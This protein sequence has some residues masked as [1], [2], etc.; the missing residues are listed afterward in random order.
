MCEKRLLYHQKIKLSTFTT[1]YWRLRQWK[2]HFMKDKV[3][4]HYGE[5]HKD[6]EVLTDDQQKIEIMTWYV[7]VSLL[8]YV[9]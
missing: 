8:F 1:Q 7:Q 4:A 9:L 5:D 6:N 2:L 3:I